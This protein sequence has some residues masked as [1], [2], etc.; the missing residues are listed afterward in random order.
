MWRP[1]AEQL[2]YLRSDT[3]DSLPPFQK[4]HLSIIHQAATSSHREINMLKHNITGMDRV[5]SIMSIGQQWTR[6]WERMVRHGRAVNMWKKLH[7][8][9]WTNVETGA[10][11]PCDYMYCHKTWSSQWTA[12]WRYEHLPRVGRIK[13]QRTPHNRDWERAPGTMPVIINDVALRKHCTTLAG[14]FGGRWRGVCWVSD[15]G[16][17]VDGQKALGS[18]PV[19]VKSHSCMSGRSKRWSAHA[20]P[21]FRGTGYIRLRMSHNLGPTIYPVPSEMRTCARDEEACR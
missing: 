20:K 4:H 13:R 9:D 11:L 6:N 21:N 2:A 18:V 17:F 19:R 3:L 1:T 16:K 5:G 14:V 10:I 7:E 8:L 15:H 12:T